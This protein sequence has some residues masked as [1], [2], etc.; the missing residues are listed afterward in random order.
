ML[1]AMTEA[2]VTVVQESHGNVV[3]HGAGSR[4]ALAAALAGD[5]YTSFPGSRLIAPR[6]PLQAAGLPPGPRL[7]P[8]V[9][10]AA[11]EAVPAAPAEGRPFRILAAPNFLPWPQ[12]FPGF[13]PSCFECQKTMEALARAVAG[14]PA[15]ELRIRIKTTVADVADER[16][17]GVSRGVVPEDMADVTALSD[18]I[19]DASLGSHREG[20]LWADLV[21]TEG[22]TN[23]LYE[24]LE[25]RRPVLLLNLSSRRAPTVEAARPLGPGATSPQGPIYAAGCDEDL[26]AVLRAIRDRRMGQALTDAD[27]E[28]LVWLDAGARASRDDRGGRGDKSARGV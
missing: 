25:L 23:V 4:R 8:S 1:A 15:F 9:R 5:G 11:P 19:R 13:V 2:G 18:N 24:A 14:D 12:A 22:M 20:L 6:S 10:V 21:V 26:P 3:V 17:M 27:L 28:G 16:M 7:A